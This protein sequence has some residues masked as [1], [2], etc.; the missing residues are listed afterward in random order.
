MHAA[1]LLTP[2][3]TNTGS[4]RVGFLLHD[5]SVVEVENT[6]SEPEEGACIRASDLF[7]YEQRAKAF[8]HTHPG[9]SCNLTAQD[10]RAFLGY[11]LHIHYIV[12]ADGV[13]GFAVLDGEVVRCE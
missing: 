3:Y 9:G 4:E 6:H 12:G 10:R 2:F 13:A 7:A 8:W 1:D 11:P 5:G